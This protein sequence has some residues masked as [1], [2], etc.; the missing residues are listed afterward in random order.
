MGP[1]YGCTG[2]VSSIVCRHRHDVRFPQTHGRRGAA[3]AVVISR[4]NIQRLAVLVL[5]PELDHRRAERHE[6]GRDGAVG[7]LDRRDVERLCAA[8][9]SKFRALKMRDEDG[10]R[11][12]GWSSSWAETS[13]S[14]ARVARP[15]ESSI[16]A[17]FETGTGRCVGVQGAVVDAY[18][19]SQDQL[20]TED[21]K[22]SP[23][24]HT[25]RATH[26]GASHDAQRARDAQDSV[27]RP[28][29]EAAR[30]VTCLLGTNWTVGLG[31]EKVIGRAV[32]VMT[33]PRRRHSGSGKDRSEPSLFMDTWDTCILGILGA[34]EV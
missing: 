24:H 23:T 33:M 30:T 25:L 20:A 1:K 2:S 29:A 6:L 15:S 34:K 17:R 26:M 7:R 5:D 11:T 16:W 14:V 13:P 21:V 9:G 22:L 3:Y 4:H 12:N 8:A 32:A 10:K 28:R 19:C 31:A 18:L 27:F